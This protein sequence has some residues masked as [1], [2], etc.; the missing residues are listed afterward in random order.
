MRERINRLARGILTAETPELSVSPESLDGEVRSGEVLR[1]S[2][3]ADS[4]NG[5]H[6][7]GLVYSDDPRVQVLRASY[8]GVR[9]RIAVEV[10]ARDLDPGEE[11]TGTL[12]FVTNGGE[13]QIPFCFRVTAG[14]AAGILGRLTSIKNFAYIAKADPESALRI[15]CY[16][17]FVRA[18]FMQDLRLRAL[19]DAFRSGADRASAME[20]FLVAS[21]A[22]Q[23]PTSL[24]RHPAA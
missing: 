12:R 23:S 3:S 17:D 10:D 15:F 21:G 4:E 6:L 13:C 20:Q 18:P 2:V 7:K 16:R 5:V 14:A 24:R 11:L 22:K 8:G 1:T 9:N 19:Y